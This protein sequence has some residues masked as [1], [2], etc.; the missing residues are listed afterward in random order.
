MPKERDERVER[1]FNRLLEATTYMSHQL[2]VNS[3]NGRP[4]SLGQALEIIIK[5]ELLRL[6]FKKAILFL[7]GSGNS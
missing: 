2:N 3:I 4:V 6:Y 5:L 1:E 7:S